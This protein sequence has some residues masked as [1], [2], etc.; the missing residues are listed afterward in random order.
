MPRINIKPSIISVKKTFTSFTTWLS[1]A[2]SHYIYYALAAFDILTVLVSLYL[3]HQIMNIYAHGV[4]VNHQWANR[5][6]ISSELSQMLTTLNTPGNNVFD[7][8]DVVAE[9]KKLAADQE[10][11]QQVINLIQDELKNKVA[12]AQST[13]LLKDLDEVEAT[14]LKMVAEAKLIFFYFSQNQPEIAGRHMAKMDRRYYQATNA[15]A[16]FRR[17]INQ[18]QQEFLEE[19]KASANMF[20]LYEFTIAAAVLL[21]ISGVTF[22]GHQLA[23][24]MKSDVESQKKSIVELRLAQVL[25]QQQKQQLE[26]TLENLQ[27]TQLQLVQSEKMSS[28]G[29]LVAGVAHEVNNP[30]NFI[31]ANLSHIQDYSQNLLTLIRLYKKY[32]PKPISEIQLEENEIDLGFLQEDLIKILDSMKMGT[33]RIRQIVLSLRNFSRMDEAECK[34]VDIHAGID[35][36]L[37]ILQHR[38]K[39]TPNRPAIAVI[40][41]YANLPRVE[42]FAGNMNQVFMNILTNAIDA[43]EEVNSNRSYEEIQ[44]NPHRITIRTSVIDSDWVQIA[45]AD[46]GTGIPQLIQQRI[47]D[48]FFTT[49][50][51][52][53]GT[54]MGMS[55]SYQIIT[56]KHGGK[57]ECFST[58]NQG[59]EF[60][61][62]IPIRQK[63]Y[64]M[65]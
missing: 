48:P 22:Y 32:Y 36:T 50:P 51:V 12:P 3:N 55:I 31:H 34:R 63:V 56:E 35:S 33:D 41:D 61:I 15:L 44:H 39:A 27:K 14:M 62:Q 13:E 43:L 18:I 7:S 10:A 49:K 29:Q 59:T 21:M 47:F 16:Q 60:V 28:L 64:E 24:K 20:R 1:V 6:Q 46:N 26:L 37:L 17:G 40:K 9:S 23:T 25:L 2:K 54:G 52:G 11:C 42:C 57:L 45:I 8:G 65:A 4:E 30:V 19:Q 38:L 5:L 53:K 58:P